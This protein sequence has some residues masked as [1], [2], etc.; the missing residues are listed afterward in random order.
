MKIDH[1]SVGG[2]DLAKME[3]SF[4]EANMKTEY[5]GPHSSGGTK[6]SLL[7]FKD[8]SYIELIS[9][10]RP[11]VR[12]TNWRLQIEGNGGPCAWAVAED[13]IA[14]QV[15]KAR[16]YGIAASGPGEYSRRRP[17]GVSV[18]WELGF[19][20]EG[21]IGAVLPFMIKDRTP[22]EFRVRPSPSVSGGTLKGIRAVVIGVR[23]IGQSMRLFE[24][25]YDW[26]E[27]AITQGP[28]EGVRLANFTGAPVVLAEPA[29][30]A[31]LSERLERFGECPCAF[32]IGSDDLDEAG[33][34]HPLEA[35]TGWFAGDSIRWV[36]PLREAGMMIGLVGR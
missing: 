5:G 24:E 27:P 20:G 1:V 6:M 26:G 3:D 35:R 21:E 14:G 8:G 16:R 2:S 28:W 22:R 11:D 12:A 18:D 29:G 9:T 31:W 13:D 19:L 33:K 7:G 23:D 25:M 10:V 17:D 15:A 30:A 36:S 34:A 32:L 4:S